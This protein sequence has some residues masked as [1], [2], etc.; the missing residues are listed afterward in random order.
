M[1]LLLGC[2]CWARAAPDDQTPIRISNRHLTL[3]FDRH[4]GAWIGLADRRSGQELIAGPAPQAMVLP[5]PL[6]KLDLHP[7]QQAVA[8]GKAI[9]LGRDWLYTPT[10]PAPNEAAEYV[11]GRFDSGQWEPTS[12]PSRRG[13]GDDRLHNRFGEFFYRSEFTCP[14]DWPAEEMA[15]VMGAVDDFDATYVNGTHVGATGQEAPR[16][17]Q[18]ARV[19][20]FPAQLLK[21]GAPNTLLIK[22]T[23]A[24]FDGGIDGPVVVGLASALCPAE[25][26][27]P[28]LSHFAV[29]H[30]G[31]ATVLTMTTQTEQYEYRMDYSL[32]E[33]APWFSRQLTVRNVG[34]KQ[35]LLRDVACATPPLRLGPQQAVVFPGSLPVGDSPISTLQQGQWLRPKSQDPLA[36]LW[37]AAE[38]QGLGTWYHCE[39]EFSPVFVRRSGETAEIQHAQQVVVRLGAGKSV[40]LGKQFFW[41]AQGS[42]DDLLQGVQQVYRAIGLRA[43][44]HTLAGLGEMV[45]YCGHPG[46]TP[47]QKFR[48]YGGFAALRRYLPTLRQMGVDLVWLLPIWEHGDGRKWNLYAPFDHFRISPLYGTPEELKELSAAFRESGIRLMFD[49]VPHGPPDFTP[50]AQEHPEWISLD[51]EGKR[52]YAWGQYAFDNAHPGWQDYMRRAAEWDAREYGAI[53]ARVDCGAGGPLNWNPAVGDRPSRSRLA[54]GLGMNRAIRAGF[55]QVNPQVVLLL[56]EY[57]GANI[58]YRVA[59]LTY[60]AQFY[61]L[62]VELDARHAPPEEWA[63]ALQQFLHDQQLTLPPGALKMRF[64]SNHDTVSWTFQK[65]RPLGRYG[66]QRMRALLALCALV[67]GVPMLYQGDED[68]AVYGG[69]GSSSVEFLQCIY[70]PRKKLPALRQG[71]ADYNAVQA[72][73]GVFACLREAPGQS[74]LVLV[75]LN[76]QAVKS[77]VSAAN[78]ALRPSGRATDVLNGSWTDELSGQT[79]RVER[80]FKIAMTPGQVRVLIRPRR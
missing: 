42:R 76:P 60:D 24:G 28:P 48:G 62:M 77:A 13:T 41:L 50:L 54:G 36:V 74:A 4:R 63:A 1:A 70:H 19:Y 52:Q 8:G 15:I 78:H 57:T 46:G 26:S 39:E 66:P 10:P 51:A 38:Q 71:K 72:T 40:T 44:D 55:L 6:R 49:L 18:T 75:S 11:R 33:D 25:R 30:K 2:G 59:D 17:W 5:P 22:V 29:T 61:F 35:A 73:S 21:R 12:I 43:P 9:D 64:I 68:P 65:Q 34:A 27:G 58:F 14:S 16:H 23:N 37:D 67:E 32:P 20:R 56:E 7:V 79:V 45:L 69:K 3:S 80:S 31:Q 47:E 53:G